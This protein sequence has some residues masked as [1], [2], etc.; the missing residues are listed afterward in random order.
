MTLAARALRIPSTGRGGWIRRALTRPET[1]AIAGVIVAFAFFA[2][3][4]PGSGFLTWGGTTNYLE[5]AAIIGIVATPVTLLLIAGDF[6]LSVGASVAASGGLVSL[7]TVTAGLPF[8]VAL[9]CGFVAAAGVG[10]VNGFLVTTTRIPSFLV[11]LAV[12]YVLQGLTLPA[13]KAITGTTSVV[14]IREASAGD[15]IFALFRGDW[16]GLPVAVWWWIVVTLIAAVVL[17]ATRFGNW[18]FVSGGNPEAGERMGVPVRRVK[19]VLY[20]ATACSA[21]IVGVLLAASVDQADVTAGRGM[22]FQAAVAAVIGGS[23]ITGGY[24]SPIGTFFGALLFGMVSQ[25]FFYTE[26]EGSYFLAFLGTMLLIAVGV[27]QYLRNASM[28]S[29]KRRP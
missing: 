16:W 26:L 2:I 21:V 5:V 6:D 3:A 23:L 20:G 15:P 10:A 19:I 8:W 11:T 13:I 27:N 4:A 14:G 1:T 22:E 18:I 12:M 17:G 25:G 28:K 24:G 9:L 7:L 29:A